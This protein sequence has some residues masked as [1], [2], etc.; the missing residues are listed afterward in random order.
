M[1]TDV[2]VVPFSP[3]DERSTASV[4]DAAANT[5]YPRRFSMTLA[6]RMM[7]ASSSTTITVSPC[8]KGISAARSATSSAHS[9]S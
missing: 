3:H 8:P 2:R 7:A 6:M 5:V 9:A 1:S 4:G